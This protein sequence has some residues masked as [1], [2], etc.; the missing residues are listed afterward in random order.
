MKTIW[1]NNLFETLKYLDI[2]VLMCLSLQYKHETLSFSR[3][4]LLKI[5]VS[6]CNISIIKCDILFIGNTILIQKKM[7]IL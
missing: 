6:S 1:E 4:C 2:I 7:K 3:T 5:Q